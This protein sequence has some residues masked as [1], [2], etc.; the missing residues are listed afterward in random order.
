[1]VQAFA[2][3]SSFTRVAFV[4]AL[5]ATSTYAESTYREPY[6][7]KPHSSLTPGSLCERPSELRYVEQ[8]KYCRRNVSGAVK[9]RVFTNYERLGYALLRLFPRE[10][11]KVDHYIPLCAGG[12]NEE[13]NL[14]PQHRTVYAI[15]DELEQ[16][17][18]QKMLLGQLR[19]SEA[20]EIIH[21]GKQDL[22]AVKGLLSS[23]K[24]N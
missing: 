13:N 20:V 7:I 23:L 18:C 22:E 4:C 10:E 11:F 16:V 1:M 21:R 3:L 15:T 6:P 19:Q 12:S 2:F 8:I 9:A 17:V 14:W 24:S 5:L